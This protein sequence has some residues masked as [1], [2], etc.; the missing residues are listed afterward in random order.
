MS[1][2]TLQEADYL[3]ETKI[4]NSSMAGTGLAKRSRHFTISTKYPEDE[5]QIDF[6]EERV[7]NK[8]RRG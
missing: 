7:Y 6:I 5:L 3:F 4:V 2:G 1:G 8:K